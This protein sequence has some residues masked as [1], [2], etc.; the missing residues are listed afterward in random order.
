[1]VGRFRNF[2]KIINLFGK[3]RLTNYLSFWQSNS[4]DTPNPTENAVS[5]AELAALAEATR[6]GD[7]AYA[8]QVAK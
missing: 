6:R 2:T 5:P 4:I 1:V 7:A 8:A 3:Y